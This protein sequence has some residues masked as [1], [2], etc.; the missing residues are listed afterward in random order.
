MVA[1]DTSVLIAGGEIDH[2]QFDPARA[3][4]AEVR[5]DGRLIA[6]TL[7]ETYSRLTTGPFDWTADAV[8]RYLARF[9]ERAPVGLAPDRYPEALREL[10]D[11]GVLGPALYDGLIAISARDA[12]LTLLSLDLRARPTYA[13]VGLDVRMLQE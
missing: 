6:H 3:A 1:P 11:K 13:A 9:L 10:T 12:G 4:L 5:D 7:A 8:H 2:P